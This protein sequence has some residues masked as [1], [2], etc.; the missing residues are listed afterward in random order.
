MREN[1]GV[2]LAKRAHLG[3]AAEAL[4]EIERGH[5][6][7]YSELNARANRVAHLLRA[8]GVQKGDRVACLL[9]NGVESVESYF[10]VAKIG[11]VL[12]PL[13]WRLV[14]DELEFILNDS[15][16]IILIYDAEVAPA[17]A[18]LRNRATA[19]Q[20]W[21]GVGPAGAVSSEDSYERAF[22]QASP[23]EPVAAGEGDDL[24][25]IMYTSGTT[26]RPKGAMHTHASMIW[27]SL[28]W[29]M[30]CELRIGDRDLVVLPLFHIGALLPLTAVLH[31]GSTAVVMRTYDT[32][33]VLEVIQRERISTMLLVTTI[34]QRLL[35]HPDRST[36][37]LG[38]LRWSVVGGSPV[39]LD[40]LEQCAMLGIEVRQD[41]GLTESGPVTVTSPEEAETKMG[42][43]GKACFHTDVRIAD[44][45][46]YEVPRGELGEIIVR[47]RH[48]MTGY[49]NRPAATAAAIRDGWLYTGD[50]GVMDHDG[51]LWVRDRKTD[52]IISGGENIY[53]AEVESV[54]LAHPAVKEVA[55][56][57]I[58]SVKWGESPAAVVV[59]EAGSRPAEE[60]LIAY[61]R[62]KMAA[63]KI[64]RRVA[65]VGQLPRTPTGKVQKQPLR[66]LFEPASQDVNSLLTPRA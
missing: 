52:V 43:A 32:R 5:R 49:W 40:L 48:V 3:P 21:L 57:G 42:S 38:S 1:L 30:T 18:A 26:G 20:T 25:F 4:V 28:T 12:V 35:A 33:A 10:G 9:M 61:C 58:P 29:N 41:Y 47:G 46:G 37:D 50:L 64:P 19:V 17:V 24:L 11:A 2:F 65:F 45:S 60:E 31:R 56:I 7:T 63:Y 54:L 23:A 6:F 36:F 8:K 16:A 15:G 66:E 44:D 59:A 22:N 53:P 13:N 39:P 55:V 34:L 14:P 51:S 27:G 62:T